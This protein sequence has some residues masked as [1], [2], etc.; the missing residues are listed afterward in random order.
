[1]CKEQAVESIQKHTILSVEDYLKGEKVSP[2]KHEYVGGEI[3]AMVGVSKPHN[4]ITLALSSILRTSLRGGPCDVFIAEMKVHARLRGADVFYY[5]DVVV[6]CQP[7]D[8]E[9][10]YTETPVLVAEV[11]SPSTRTI[12]E[13]EKRIAYQQID[14]L[15]EY[16]LIEQDRPE[17]RVYRRAEN[18]PG[19]NWQLET[20]SDGDTMRLTSVNLTIPLQELYENAWR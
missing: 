6:D 8:Q 2:V 10:Y 20:F 19:E 14:T 7:S 11:L 15:Q 16:L 12:D 9:L 3:Y 4:R 17:V 18:A 1:V 5:P 13:R